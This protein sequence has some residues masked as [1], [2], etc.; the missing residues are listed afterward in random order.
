MFE[1][2]FCVTLLSNAQVQNEFPNNNP[3]LFSNRLPTSIVLHGTWEVGVTQV[4]FTNAL[5]FRTPEYKFVVWIGEEGKDL[6]DAEKLRSVSDADKD[7]FDVSDIS[8]ACVKMDFH[9]IRFPAASWYTVAELGRAVASYI[10]STVGTEVTFAR[11]SKNS[12]FTIDSSKTLGI[13]SCDDEL[14]DVLG[15]SKYGM[16]KKKTTLGYGFFHDLNSLGRAQR[17]PRRPEMLFIYSNIVE[18]SI[19]GGS[20]ANL[21]K[22]V[23]ITAHNGYMQVNSYLPPVYVKVSESVLQQIDIVMCDCGSHRIEFTDEYAHASIELHFR[24]RDTTLF[25]WV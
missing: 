7:L 5:K 25:P 19:V 21:L 15:V 6:A 9:I 4:H 3:G 14:F 8:D 23:P 24:K 17:P 10:S 13:T 20:L 16:N 2:E 11:S 1:N 18:K 12:V 22:A